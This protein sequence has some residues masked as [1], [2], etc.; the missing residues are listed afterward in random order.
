M[1]RGGDGEYGVFVSA[2]LVSCPIQYVY[3]VSSPNFSSS[4]RILHLSLDFP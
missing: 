1:Y 2:G 3:L 4:I